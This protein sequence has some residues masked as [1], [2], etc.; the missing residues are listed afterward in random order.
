MG[1]VLARR[2]RE[3]PIRLGR[4]WLRRTALPFSAT[5]FGIAVGAALLGW[6]EFRLI[7]AV[8]AVAVAI[9]GYAVM[10]LAE[11]RY[12]DS[13][14]DDEPAATWQWEP[15]G[16]PKLDAIVLAMWLLLGAANAT[17]GDWLPSIVWTGLAI[18]WAVTS[19]AEGRWRVGSLG[20]SPA[21]HV[22]DAGLVKRRPYTRSLV[23]WSDISHVRL[24]E[25]ELVLDQGFFDVRFERDQLA[26]LEA[27]RTEIERHRQSLRNGAPGAP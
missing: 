7:V 18:L 12:V 22:H 13:V 10:R 21:I 6:L 15:P 27:A 25:D 17:T 26:D 4:N 16:T 23:R 24:C 3:L 2:V 1:I 20:D 9:A 14:T 5:P 8:L 11:A 19:L